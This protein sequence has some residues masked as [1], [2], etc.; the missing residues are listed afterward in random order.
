MLSV[1]NASAGSGKTFRLT[2]E[3]L[4][5]LLARETNYRRI[6]AVTFTNKATAEMKERIIAQLAV[7]S[8]EE[9]SAYRDT[10]I[11]ETGLTA[12]QIR[13]SAQISLHNI[14]FDY[15][16]FSVSTIDR[17]TQRIL[18]AFSRET[19]VNPDY[20]TET[21]SDLLIEEAV[22]RIIANCDRNPRL[23]KW[24]ELFVSE[25]IS[26]NQNF[27][28]ENDLKELGK[29]LF[30]EKLQNKLQLL[31]VFFSDEKN[32]HHYLELLYKISA[33][34]ESGLKT[35]AGQL[36][37]IYTDAGYGVGD[38]S[39]GN[40]G[41]AGF[42]EKTRK[43]SIPLDIP[44]R[45]REASQ[46]PMAW[47]TRANRKSEGIMDLVKKILQPGLQIMVDFWE[48]HSPGYFTAKT[49]IAEWYTAALLMDIQKEVTALGREKGVLPLAISNLLLKSIIDGSDAPFIFEKA[50]NRYSHFMLDEF[51]DTSEM[52]WDNFRPLIANSMAMGK[53][54]II[55]GDVKQ[56][57]YR[58]RNS[59]WN[60]LDERIY[61]DFANFPVKEFT[62]DKNYRSAEEIITFNNQF[63]PKFLEKVAG[64]GDGQTSG[65]NF[66]P[67]LRHL[68]RNIQQLPVKSREESCG[69]VGI[70][71]LDDRE[72]PFEELT[73]RKLVDEVKH[74]MDH[75]FSAR[76][77][78]VLVRK[79]GEGSRIVNHF[80]KIASLPENINYNLRIVSGES[81]YLQS[82]ASVSFIIHLFRYLLNKEE[83]L[84]KAT[85]LHLF[86]NYLT[87]TLNEFPGSEPHTEGYLLSW[88]LSEEGLTEFDSKIAPVISDIE[89]SI[90]INSIDQLILRICSDFKL[91]E[92]KEELPFLQTL[93]DKAAEIRNTFP[94]GISGF[95][96]WW[97]EKG[98]EI[99][100]STNDEVDAIRLLT[101]HKCKGLE[102][103][104]VL[105]PFFN[106]RFSDYKKNILWCE[107]LETPFNAV[108]MVPVNYSKNLANTIFKN[109]YEQE[110]CN[111]LIDNLNLVY[112]AFTRAVSVLWINVPYRNNSDTIGASLVNAIS[113]LSLE[114]GFEKQSPD[115]AGLFDYGTIPVMKKTVLPMDKPA[116]LKWKFH[117]F[118]E[119]LKLRTGSDDFLEMAEQ[120]ITKKNLGKAVHAILAAIKTRQDMKSACDRALAAGTILSEEAE[121][122]S[123]QIEQMINHPVASEWFGGGCQVFTETD[124]LTSDITLRPDRMMIF[125]DHAIVVDYK[126]GVKETG[127]HRTQVRRYVD[128]LRKTGIQEVKGYLWYI[129]ENELIEVN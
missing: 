30:K 35:S 28:V 122:I 14:L 3:Y 83:L 101:I 11:E 103:N 99:A 116:E 124:L 129:Q 70:S 37:N 19:G 42:L 68:Y 105:I 53:K 79:N 95:L 84:V 88:I 16:R 41:V 91:L 38:F 92:L 76:D 57:I 97:E 13:Q 32:S 85:L 59:N 62:L 75:G 52:Q 112:V 117:D 128:L 108:P 45:V 65:S 33:G 6:L 93:I 48:K 58:W 31:A 43:G 49:I 66:A 61:N 77:F 119:R 4:K 34:F 26:N 9:K 46:D 90:T 39:Y 44:V 36:V 64:Y 126:T 29:E 81:F 111:I 67:K 73:L 120:G 5:L 21:D 7:L 12:E 10:I 82:S 20:Q 2:T 1:Y 100:V 71:R 8:G 27:S 22:D 80:V 50:G 86:N 60:L 102:F 107:P 63:F 54:N 109:D 24:L 25:K 110:L 87:P 55:V 18:K 115:G 121:M 125:K 40:S 127:S 78:A 118:S 113:D 89:K 17:F 106:W 98:C 56:S 15:T 74:L 114:P 23:L 104:V 51:Q 47:L 123:D 94:G 96:E 72:E 69:F